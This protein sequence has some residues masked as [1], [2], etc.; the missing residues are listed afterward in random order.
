M[1]WVAI[2]ILLLINAG[3]YGLWFQQKSDVEQLGQ[4]L[5]Q[6]QQLAAQSSELKQLLQS[7]AANT[8]VKLAAIETAQQDL[9]ETIVSLQQN[10]QLGSAEIQ[11]KWAIA[12][13][14]YLL[15][16]ANHRLLLAND[17]EGALHALRLADQRAEAMDDYRLHSLRSLLA[18][19]QM[20]LASLA[21]ID[22][23]GMVLQLQSAVNNVDTLQAW[24][25]PEV[26]QNQEVDTGIAEANDWQQALANMWTQVRSM[27]VIRHKQDGAA[28]VLVPEQRYFLYQNLRLQLETARYA[29]LSGEEPVFK[30]SIES[31][32]NW[33]EQYFIGDEK[34]AMSEL[35]TNMQQQTIKAESPDI[36]SSLTWLKSQ[37]SEQ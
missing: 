2:V 22:I 28:A 27:V 1:I 34:E 31:A 6:N 9:S 37:G 26:A 20:A 7:E 24:M 32:N 25:G 3:S 17:T 29:L 30:S 12:E 33:L 16:V 19:E 23:E 5:S 14:E 36:S 13:L 8:K 11:W 15:T 35:L 4:Q 18:D 21:K 10:Q